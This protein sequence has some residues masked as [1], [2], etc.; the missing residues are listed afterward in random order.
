MA[1]SFAT[2][3]RQSVAGFVT[4]ISLFCAPAFAVPVEIQFSGEVDIVEYDIGNT[5]YSGTTPGTQISGL[6]VFDNEAPTTSFCMGSTCIYPFFGPEYGG[7]V[8]GGAFLPGQSVLLIQD[9][10]TFGESED[11]LEELALANFFLDPDINL[12]TPVDF[13]EVGAESES[14][15]GFSFIGFAALTLNT[16]LQNGPGFNPVPPTATADAVVFII[17]EENESGGEFLALGRVDDFTVTVIPLPAAGWL[18]FAALGGLAGF[19]R[20]RRVS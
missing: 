6:I 16:S 5:S 3:R 14:F 19:A 17:E 18:L 1:R 8:D 20:R 2:R 13:W 4:L 11:P 12:N 15:D 7:S 10:F 9:D